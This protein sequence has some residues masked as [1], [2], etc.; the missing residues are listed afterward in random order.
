[1]PFVFDMRGFW[2]DERVEGLLWNLKNP[3]FL[4]VYRYF[5]K[6][7]RQFFSES[8]HVVSLTHKGKEEILKMKLPDV[9]AEKI[10]VIPCCTDMD[11][12]VPLTDQKI[13][14]ERRAALSIPA[15]SRVISYLGSF[16]TWYM[17][18]EMLAFI[19]I[20]KQSNLNVIFLIISRDEPERILS[21]ATDRG[22]GSEDLRIVSAKR[23]EVPQWLSLSDETLFFIRPTF[24]KRASSPTKMGEAL[25]MGIPVICNDGIG[26]CTEILQT[27][28]AGFIVKSFTRESYQKMAGVLL[29]RAKPEPG[30]IRA[31]AKERLDLKMGVSL[32]ERI[33]SMMTTHKTEEGR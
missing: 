21:L 15:D 18:E 22:L 25:S 4:W 30:R 14:D 5:K 23:E 11:L 29:S 33:Y 26:D 9:T 27:G 16:G 28:E 6:K 13:L 8:R 17:A 20:L 19:S 24:S 3:V 2:A 31:V 7:E 12:F 1:M 10:T 32:Y